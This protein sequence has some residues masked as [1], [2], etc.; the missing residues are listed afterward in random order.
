LIAAMERAGH[1][2]RGLTATVLGAG[3]TARAAAWA[4]RE[5]G[6]R[7]V[8]V[9]NRTP[10]RARELARAFGIRAVRLPESTDIL[11]NCT[12]VGLVRPASAPESGLN[13]LSLKHDLVGRYSYVV[14]FVYG[15]S[16]TELLALA[17]EQGVPTL[18]GL[19]LLVAQGAL[20]LERWTGRPALLEVMRSAAREAPA[21]R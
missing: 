2:P 12:S 20:S 21:G 17:G 6:A 14:D 15:T 4:L 10:E 7:E 8:S 3:G 13:L 5:A 9:W 18:D 19:E 16:P 11:I 1:A